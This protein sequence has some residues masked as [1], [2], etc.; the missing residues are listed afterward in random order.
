PPLMAAAMREAV[1]AGH[2]AR[3]AGRIP[4][5]FWAQASSPPVD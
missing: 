4:K 3:V 2:A 5:R 1:R